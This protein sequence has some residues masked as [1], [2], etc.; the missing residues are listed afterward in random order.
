MG[1][2]EGWVRKKPWKKSITIRSSCSVPGCNNLMK[3]KKKHK[4]GTWTYN[5]LCQRHTN[6][7]YGMK[8]SSKAVRRE[9]GVGEMSS[10]PCSKCGWNRSYCDIHRVV[11]GK[12][13][14]KYKVTNV[15]TL[16]PNCHRELHQGTINQ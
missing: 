9:V 12:D 3:Y 15:I 4:D 11:A 5:E 7:K 10:K 16:C 8:M 2:V 6:L 1:H 13:G 14:G